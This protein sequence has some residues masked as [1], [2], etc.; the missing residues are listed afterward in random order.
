MLAL[1]TS[2]GMARV[3]CDTHMREILAP[4]SP[5][6]LRPVFTSVFGQLQRGKALEA[7]TFLE[8]HDLLARD[9]TEYFA[10]KTMHGASCLQRVHRPGAV[11]YAPQMVGAALIHPDLRAVIPLMPEPSV[12]GD[13]ATTHDC[14]RHAAQRFVAKVRQAPPPENAL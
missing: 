9:G 14:E 1:P 8:G 10:S 12:N 4:V 13:G 5:K 11:T 6:W 2:Y 7:M 3:P